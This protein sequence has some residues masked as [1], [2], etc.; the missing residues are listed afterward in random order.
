MLLETCRKAA[1][2]AVG[3]VVSVREAVERN[4]ALACPFL[5]RAAAGTV[6]TT[7]SLAKYILN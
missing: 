7:T 1:V 6:T 4:E 2:Q 3:C 5:C